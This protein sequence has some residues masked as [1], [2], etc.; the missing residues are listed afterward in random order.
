MNYKIESIPSFKTE[1][2]KLSK[3]YRNLKNDYKFLLETLSTSNNPK[4][5]GISLGKNCYKIRL[6]NS[7]NSK[8]KSAGY[9]V[10]YFVIENDELITLLSIYSKQI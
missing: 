6:K 8:G 4:E 5:I 9:R 10:I 1:L 7:D 3:K 2:K